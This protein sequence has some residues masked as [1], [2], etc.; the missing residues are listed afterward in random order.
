MSPHHTPFS[1]K[2][3]KKMRPGCSQFFQVFLPIFH[4]NLYTQPLFNFLSII[5]YSNILAISSILGIKVRGGRN[6]PDITSSLWQSW[7]ENLAFLI[8][9]CCSY[10]NW[11]VDKIYSNVAS[12]FHGYPANYKVAQSTT[13]QWSWFTLYYEMCSHTNVKPFAEG[14]KKIN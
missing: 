14:V 6:Y 4:K 10:S 2:A 5:V 12:T 7:K 13:C 1:R 11:N 3:N 9:H 8:P